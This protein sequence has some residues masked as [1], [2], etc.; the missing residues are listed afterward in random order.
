MGPACAAL[1]QGRAWTPSAGRRLALIDRDPSKANGASSGAS[2]PASREAAVAAGGAARAGKPGQ[3][4]VEDAATFSKK[5]DPYEQGGKPLDPAHAL[6]LMDTVRR[7]ALP[8][9]G[10][11]PRAPLPLTVCCAPMPLAAG[12]KVGAVRR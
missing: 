8:H 10:A 12:Q 2:Q 6:A 9:A 1:R 4:T 11:V 7:P 5:C 3:W